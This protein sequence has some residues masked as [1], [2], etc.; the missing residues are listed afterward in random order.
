[1]DYERIVAKVEA[2]K[3]GGV[4]GLIKTQKAVADELISVINACLVQKDQRLDIV[5]F[6]IGIFHENIILTFRNYFKKNDK[7][8]D[9]IIDAYNHI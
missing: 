7:N 9:V 1:M 6:Y 3:T 2:N 5:K 8:L 4:E